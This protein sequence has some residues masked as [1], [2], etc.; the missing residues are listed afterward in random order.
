MPVR[1]AVM[2]EPEAPIEL[3]ELDDPA[4]ED[5]SVLLE[6][7]A[8][9]VC[10]T[11]V[12]LHHGRL[13]GVPYPIVPGHVSVGRVLEAR[14]V[15]TDAVGAAIGPG[16]EV[17]F[18]DVHETCHDCYYCTVARQP[19]RCPSRRVYGIT[20]SA[21]DGPLGGWAERIYLKPGVRVI[22][23]PDGLSADDVIGG[24]CGLFTGFAT[25]ERSGLAMGDTVVVQG[26]GPVGLSAAA[27][28]RLRGAGTVVVIGAPR[29]RLDLALQLG[30]DVVLLL[31]EKSREERAAAINDLTAGR[32]TDVVIE[33]SGNPEAVAEGL[34]LLRDGGTYVIGG[35][36]T[37]TGSV[38]INPHLQV[39]RKHADVRGQW[40]TD[41]H[42]IVRA[43]RILAKHR[44]RL[45]FDRVIGSRYGLE[46]ANQALDD[47]A[48]LRVTKAIIDPALGPGDRP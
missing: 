27:F 34:D 36:Y 2:T 42:H 3:W 37:D 6:T 12:H 13:A 30:A 4:L 24:G 44:Q 22:K 48:S 16:D 21:H 1:A 39:N 10:G 32:G 26:S 15:D 17:T 28:S 19:N 7:V 14:G 29:S 46:Q 38:S 35:H 31:Q 11:D 8:S 40:G 5:G 18:Y 33:A 23:L 9:E 45:P 20:Y 43:L 25:V 47:V 41:F